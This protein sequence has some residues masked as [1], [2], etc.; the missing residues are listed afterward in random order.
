MESICLYDYNVSFA[1]AKPEKCILSFL[2]YCSHI[3]VWVSTR[4]HPAHTCRE[5]PAG[6]PGPR[7][8]PLSPE[9]LGSETLRPWAEPLSP[10]LLGSE[11]LRPWAEPLSPE[12][13]GPETLRPWAE[14]LQ[15]PQ[16]E[17]EGQKEQLLMVYKTG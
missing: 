16:E 13:L 1:Y 2:H 7:V 9:L 10:E 11:T 15:L 12:L 8:K 14:L 5:L 6:S 3:L 4:L 17:E